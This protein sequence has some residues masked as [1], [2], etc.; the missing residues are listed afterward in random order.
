M[1]HRCRITEDI[2]RRKERTVAGCEIIPLS[3]RLSSEGKPNED[4]LEDVL[5]HVV[6]GGWRVMGVPIYIPLPKNSPGQILYILQ[7]VNGKH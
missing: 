6:G 1:L 2:Y 4:D 5:D 3:V 7:R